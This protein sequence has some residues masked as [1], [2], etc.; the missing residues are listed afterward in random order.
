MKNSL[1]DDSDRE[2]LTDSDDMVRMTAL[3]LDF[4]ITALAEYESMQ[5]HLYRMAL[6]GIQAFHDFI[7]TIDSD[8]VNQLRN[9]LG[10]KPMSWKLFRYDAAHDAV[11]HDRLLELESGVTEMYAFW[12]ILQM[13]YGGLDEKLLVVLKRLHEATP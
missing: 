11:L 10:P 6:E 8:G 1:L 2:F 4:N 12:A 9:E 7:K 5:P 13:C 3:A